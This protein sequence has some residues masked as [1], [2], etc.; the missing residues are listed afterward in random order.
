MMEVEGTVAAKE[1]E[2]ID[3]DEEIDELSASFALIEASLQD[4]VY[5][6]FYV[7]VN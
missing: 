3:G 4:Q 5:W 1:P 7:V 6:L 2:A